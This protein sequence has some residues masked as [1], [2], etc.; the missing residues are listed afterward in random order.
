MEPGLH[1]VKGNTPANLNFSIQWKS[2]KT[3]VKRR[4]FSI[5]KYKEFATSG[6][7]QKKT[8]KDIFKAEGEDEEPKDE[9]HWG[10]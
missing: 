1:C 10:R 6:P 4:Q 8:W 9:D 3:K 7:A 2:L 5:N